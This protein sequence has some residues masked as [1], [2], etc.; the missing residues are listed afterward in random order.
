M[1]TASP[2]NGVSAKDE[3]GANSPGPKGAIR[4]A[5]MVAVKTKA[6]GTD[7]LIESRHDLVVLCFEFRIGIIEDQDSGLKYGIDGIAWISKYGLQ[8]NPMNV[9]VIDI[10]WN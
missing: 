6:H 8:I 9:I 3:H 5:R 7:C 4:F 1:S 2:R 10:I